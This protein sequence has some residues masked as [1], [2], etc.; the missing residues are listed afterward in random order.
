MLALALLAFF[1]SQ[2]TGASAAKPAADRYDLANGCYAVRSLAIDRYIAKTGG[3]YSASATSAA[4]AEPFFMEPPELGR[5]LFYGPA[6]DFLAAKGDGVA[7]A[8]EP[9]AAAEWIVDEAGEGFSITSVSA[10][11]PLAAAGD[12]K[13]GLGGAGEFAFEPVKGCTDYPEVDV[14]ATGTPAGGETSYGETS[15]LIDAHMHMMAFDFLGGAAHCGRPWHR[16]GAPYALVDCP[17]HYPNGSAAILEN[18]LSGGS[19]PTHD[20]VGW[21][22]FKDWPAHDS[23]T[24]EQSYYK[25]L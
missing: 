19:R 17:D 11:K 14:S 24:H 23:L 22:T 21:P 16:Y 8:S 18:A 1:A 20:P 2:P 13:L 25:W 4:G 9:S 12:G 3:A 6:G 15:G 7:P 10:D 5:Y